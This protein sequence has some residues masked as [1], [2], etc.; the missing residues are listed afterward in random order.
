MLKQFLELDID[1]ISS[2]TEAEKL[3]KNLSKIITE[4]NKAYYEK[5]Q[6]IITDEQYDHL[7][8]LMSKLEQKFPEFSSQDSPIL[9]IGAAASA[10]FK[11]VVRKLPMLSLNNAFDDE[12]IED[13]IKKLQNFLNLPSSEFP[14]FCCE[15]KIDG[16][17]F[18]A[19]Y[20]DGKLNIASTRGD[21]LVGEDITNNIKT[22]KNF[23]LAL[24]NAPYIF[25]VRGEI[26]MDKQDFIK[27]NAINQAS[28]KELF[29]NPRNAAAGS[30]RQLDPAITASR[31]LKYFTYAIGEVKNNEKDIIKEQIFANTQKELLEKLTEFGFKVNENYI[32]ASSLEEMRQ[33]YNK[34][35]L[36][37]DSLAFEIDGIVYKVNNHELYE[38]L[39]FT[40]KSPRGAIAHKFPAPSS[41]TKLLNVT[42]QVGRSGVITPVAELAPC[43]IG[44]ATIQRA[45]LH[46][47]T[48]IKRKDIRIND[49]V[50]LQRAG[51]VI[52]K[53]IA[54]DFLMRTEESQIIKAPSLCPSC[55]QALYMDNGGII[56]RCVNNKCAAQ[57][58]EKICH[59]VSRG[60]LNIDGI[61]KKQI[62]LLLQENIIKN[63]IDLL[64]LPNSDS[65]L[66]RKLINFDGFGEKSISNLLNN[67]E[68][69]KKNIALH[70]FIYSLGINQI[71][72]NNARILASLFN[73]AEEFLISMKKLSLF[74]D[75]EIY[76]KILSVGGFGEKTVLE[77]KEFFQEENNFE[78]TQNLIEILE[79]M[80]S[81]ETENTS[82]SGKKF[83]FTGSLSISRAEAKFI[84]QKKGAIVSDSVSNLTDFVIAGKKA[85]GAKIKS[86]Q[87]LNKIILTEEE[88][89]E[90]IAKI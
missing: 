74:N 34:E 70:I 85:N 77:I 2:S 27:L 24:N 6:P 61:G 26:Y 19:L 58:Y 36:N 44:G 47:F 50:Y 25:E 52:P 31:E 37:R 32:I 1:K 79:I 43:N 62:A 67:I 66:L 88:W 89:Q 83:V 30:L 33:F 15:Q 86:A 63:I 45:T 56:L 51:D 82:I 53:V 78:M 28:G 57:N 13:F 17:S 65:S 87:R 48:E 5:N 9:K 8:K 54:V 49:Y 71:G 90:M 3:I 14:S 40:A 29:A 72:E 4:S 41:K 10:K 60:A 7:F 42:F 64:L 35:L 21:G 18:S 11:K 46:N 12:D 59:F 76:N 55:N 84:M 73:T 80:P 20:I 69:A 23:P 22:L 38:R 16:L 39:G 75:E 68:K 81:L